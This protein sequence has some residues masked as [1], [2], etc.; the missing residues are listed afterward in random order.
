MQQNEFDSYP[1]FTE[2]MKKTHTILLPMM[3]P[4][5]FTL[6]KRILDSFG[7]KTELLENDSRDV[8][9]E[10]LKNVHNDTCY[11]ALLVIG[12][13]INALKSGKYDPDK[14]ALMITQTGGGCRASN[15]IYLLRKAL[16]KSGFGQVPVISLNFSGLDSSPGFK[17]TL[18]MILRL[19]YAVVMGDFLMLIKNQCKPYE[20]NHGETDAL[21]QRWLDIIL[22]SWSDGALVSYKKMKALYPRILEDFAAIPKTGEK[23]VRVGIVGEIYVKYSPMGNNH[24][25]DFLLAEGA[26]PVVPGLIDFCLY[27]IYNGIEDRKLYGGKMLTSQINGIAYDY[28]VAKQRDMIEAIR[29]HGVFD[30][31]MPFPETNRL[32]S[33]YI[34]HGV[35][36]GEGWL[37]TVEMAELIHEGVRNIVCT[38]PFGCLPNHIVGKGMINEIKQK[39]PDANIVAIDYDPGAS[40]VNQQNRIKLMLANASF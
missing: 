25:E 19:V 35:K 15:Y 40:E 23:K 30:P 16:K 11:P 7:Y 36:M 31:P 4:I 32:A 2:E 38:Q 12:Q 1:V 39:H 33:Q 6:M 8:I 3:L 9:N 24:L 22:A 21:V 18:P 34:S 27:C 14:V 17:L 26:E 13:M 20:Q 29:R 5:H 28:F 10:G 37:L